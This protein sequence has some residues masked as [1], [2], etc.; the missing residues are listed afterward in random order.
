MN[1]LWVIAVKDVGEAF[2][3]RS[4]Y[5]FL[6]IMV[7]V[8]FS[9][10][11]VY[12]RA[13]KSLTNPQAIAEISRTFLS[14]L[15]YVLPLMYS[16]MLCSIF[17]NYSVV[18][19]KAKRNIESLMA[20]P[21]SINQIWIGKSLAVA[22]PSVAVGLS[23]SVVAYVIMNFGFVIPKTG[24]FVFPD[25]PAIVS[26]LVIVPVL[27]FSVVT[28]VIYIQLIITNPRIASIVFT[29]IYVSLI[30]GINALGGMGVSINFFPLM[31]LGII[32]FCAAVSFVLSFSLTKEKVLLSSRA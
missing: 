13:V 27:A 20:T 31:Y 11:S 14:S 4:I 5:A 26:A 6:L 9:Y 19:D 10:I 2:S 21:V 7:V 28:V 29:V 30:L 17:A 8:S 3:S 32:V 22:L 23:I 1:K 15:A 24:S 16:I 12:N 18:L 25:A